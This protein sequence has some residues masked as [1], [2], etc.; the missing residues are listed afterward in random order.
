MIMQLD[1]RELCT[2]SRQ[3]ESSGTSTIVRNSSNICAPSGG[4]WQ[5]MA[6]A[7]IHYTPPS[8]TKSYP[9]I[10]RQI[11]IDFPNCGF[12]MMQGH[13]LRQGHRVPHARIRDCLQ[14]ID[15]DGVPIR[16]AITVQRRKYMVSSPQALWHIDGNHILIR[17]AYCACR[18]TL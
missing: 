10:A 7:Y 1:I 6:C 17:L 9:D 13:L 2:R 4:G 3:C 5:S 16:W 15:S 14:R 12:C 8:L 11:K 18:N